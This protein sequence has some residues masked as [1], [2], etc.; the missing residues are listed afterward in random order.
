MPFCLWLACIDEYV[1]TEERRA[2][3]VA[4]LRQGEDEPVIDQEGGGAERPLTVPDELKK[5]SNEE[6]ERIAI[7]AAL[8]SKAGA[9]E[10]A[11]QARSRITTQM[12]YP[13]VHRRP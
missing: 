10:S 12:R 9:A 7:G 6:A 1:L 5:Q 4:R 2:H 11:L 13:I 3:R 8:S